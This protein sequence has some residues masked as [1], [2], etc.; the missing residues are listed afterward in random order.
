MLGGLGHGQAAVVE[1]LA[2]PADGP[3]LEACGHAGLAVGKEFADLVIGQL[4]AQVAVE[5]PVARRG[6]VTFLGVA[7]CRCR[8]AVARKDHETIGAA[9]RGVGGGEGGRLAPQDRTRIHDGVGQ[10]VGL[11]DTLEAREVA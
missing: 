5:I 9:D 6:R 2:V 11:E 1:F 8:L 10:V 7:Y 4:V 3:V